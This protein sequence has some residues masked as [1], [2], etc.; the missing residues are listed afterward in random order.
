M[1]V[2]YQWGGTPVKKGDTVV[3]EL[4]GTVEQVRVTRRDSY[5]ILRE[6]AGVRRRLWLRT[7]WARDD[8]AWWFGLTPNGLVRVAVNAVQEVEWI[9]CER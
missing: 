5:L 2:F 1:R 6:R 9:E 4:V 3:T 7:A 8:A